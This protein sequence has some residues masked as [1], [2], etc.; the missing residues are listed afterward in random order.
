MRE[1]F[2]EIFASIR[3]NKLRTI[4]TGFSVAWGILL[5]MI[6]IGS[7]NGFQRGVLSHFEGRNLNLYYM[8]AGKTSTPYKG[9][10]KGRPIHLLEEHRALLQA[11]MPQI[12]DSYCERNIWGQNVTFEGETILASINGTTESKLRIEQT[13]LLDGQFISH[14]DIE[15]RRK[16]AVINS[17]TNETLFDEGQNGVGKRI[18]ISGIS[19]RV[20]GVTD[21]ERQNIS[22]Q[23]PLS[24][25]LLLYKKNG[26]NNVTMTIE[27]SGIKSIEQD[28]AFQKRVR[29]T[30]AEALQFSPTDQRAIFINSSINSYL[31]TQDVFSSIKLFLW[32]VGVA[33]LFIGVVGVSNIMIVAVKE[34]TFEFGIRKSLGASPSSLVRLVLIES[35]ITT[36]LFGYVGLVLGVVLMNSFDWLLENS[37]F[38]DMSAFGGDVELFV[39]PTVDLSSALL[40]VAVLVI[41]GMIAGYIPARRVARIK[42]IDAMRYNK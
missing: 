35:V 26:D 17:Y 3:Q 32:I 8:W 42:T 28:D 2:N 14:S 40:A 27:G 15:Q 36:S 24:T 11:K 19:F 23:I 30:L 29:A 4:L 18:L 21:E 25:H 33:T 9:F 22:V 38:L 5:L 12:V 6:L 20:I 41:S 37:D 39:N 1:L 7:G 34:R 31:S 10:Q 16:V 13:E